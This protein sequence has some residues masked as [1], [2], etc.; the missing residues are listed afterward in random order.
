MVQPPA[1]NQR[2]YHYK[3]CRMQKVI[4]HSRGI[5]YQRLLRLYYIY[6]IKLSAV[7]NNLPVR[8]F[9]S[10]KKLEQDFIACRLLHRSKK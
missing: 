2:L 5:I 1:K 8:G 9:A 4:I 10:H 3:Y 6:S 7:M